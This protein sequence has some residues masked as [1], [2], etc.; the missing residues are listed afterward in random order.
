MLV[1]LYDDSNYDAIRWFIAY[2]N[3][4]NNIAHN[5]DDSC[6]N[7][8]LLMLIFRGDFVLYQ[9]KY[10]VGIGTSSL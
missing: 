10:N 4:N 8:N 6:N 9:A 3:N 2:N 5:D 1:M 7:N